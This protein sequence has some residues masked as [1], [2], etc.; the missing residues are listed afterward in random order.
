MSC[1]LNPKYAVESGLRP[2][3]KRVERSKTAAEASAR[4]PT[5]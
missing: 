4:R 2:I 3:P 1:G 5:A